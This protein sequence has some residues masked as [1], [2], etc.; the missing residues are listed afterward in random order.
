M[1]P[2]T[3]SAPPWCLASVSGVT[4]VS[5]LICYLCLRS[6]PA[7]VQHR[8]PT[9]RVLAL[10]ALRLLSAALGSS[11]TRTA[12]D[13]PRSASLKTESNVGLTMAIAQAIMRKHCPSCV[14]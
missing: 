3:A 13:Q 4:H 8:A 7:T 2:S 10:L 11:H 5:G 6:V 14:V 12:R 9:D 1:Q